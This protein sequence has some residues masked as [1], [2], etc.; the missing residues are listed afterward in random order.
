MIGSLYPPAGIARTANAIW[1]RAPGADDAVP[2]ADPAASQAWVQRLAVVVLVLALIYVIQGVPG[3]DNADPEQTDHVSP[4]NSWIWLGLLT[5][6]MP[7]LFARWRQVVRLLLGS[8]P[9]LLL[10]AYFAAS[11]TWALDPGASSRRLLFTL[12]QLA[13]FAIL[14]TGIRRAPVVHL[15]IAA[16]CSI[17]ALAD[18]AA[19][20]VAPGS[21]MTSEGFAGL[22]SQKNQTGL[23]M[24]YGYLAVVPCCFLVRRRLVRVLLALAAILICA[25]LVASRSTTSQSVVIS[26]TFVMPLLLLI[27]RLP[28]R[29][30]L[31][32]A[33]AVLLTVLAVAF[34]YLAW[35]AHTVTDPMLPMRG[36]TFT[37]R[38]DLWTFVAGEVAKRP[39]FGAGYSSLWGI[40]PAVQPSLKTGMWFGTYAIIS[41]GHDGYLDLLA[42]GGIV[43]FTG[44]LFVVFRSIVMAARALNTAPA[45]A[46]AWTE[47]QLSYPTAA[48]YLAFLLGLIV[49]NFTESNLFSNNGLLAVAFLLT[50]LDLEKARVASKDAAESFSRRR[51]GRWTSAIPSRHAGT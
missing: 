22:Q 11:A 1:R 5:M 32:C 15:V 19:W 28:R 31:A 30:I 47:G 13:L 14:L 8:W 49:H 33:A 10:F 17:A 12:V 21:A 9:L 39:L 51:G 42:T 36:V 26:A 34:G 24:M 25:L 23:L 2:A 29:M 37:A 48:F 44:G 4:W 45:A 50:T 20:V 18:L 43:G 40:D 35:C 41:E 46:R 38:T 6:S 27:A 7:V 3:A 16:V